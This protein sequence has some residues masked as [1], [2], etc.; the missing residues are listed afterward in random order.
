MD[1]ETNVYTAPK[2]GHECG[3][4]MSQQTSTVAEESVTTDEYC[5]H[6]H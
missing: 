4:T 2:S 6:C 1:H 5:Q 3:A